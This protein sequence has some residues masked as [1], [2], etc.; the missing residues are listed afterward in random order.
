[1]TEGSETPPQRV[2]IHT[3]TWT[4]GWK[5]AGHA[6]RP[7]AVTAALSFGAFVQIALAVAL[8]VIAGGFVLWL[9]AGALAV[10]LTR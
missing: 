6:G 8:G 9:L 2:E 4:G 3:P 5:P 7:V 10:A 1:M